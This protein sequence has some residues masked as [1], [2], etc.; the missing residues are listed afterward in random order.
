MQ[1][2]D[3]SH[4]SYLQMLELLKKDYE[5]VGFDYVKKNHSKLNGSYVILRHDIDQSIEKAVE[6][7]E[8]EASLGVSAT[9]FIFLRSPFY[10]VFTPTNESNIRKILSD[11]HRIG[12][13]YDYLISSELSTDQFLENLRSET[14]LLSDF[15]QINI[16]EISFHRPHDIEF[17][18][19]L[20]LG[21]LTHSYE[22]LFIEN[23][24]YFSDSRGSWRFGHPLLSDSYAQKQNLQILTHPIWWN[25]NITSPLD[26]IHSFKK[27]FLDSFEHNIKTEL[28]GFWDT[29][30][31]DEPI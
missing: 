5:F 13:H 27:Q 8:I 7:S 26:S 20:D 21:E 25:S 2:T 24:K 17:I 18:K 3:F 29:I 23:F 6:I 22:G 14:K 12:L 30:K 9:Y 1:L 11:G 15:F 19:Q 16:N 28:K 4:K 10:N 31:K